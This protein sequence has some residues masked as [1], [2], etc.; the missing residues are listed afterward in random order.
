M[1][2]ITSRENIETIFYEDAD[3]TLFRE[4]LSLF[5]CQI[6]YKE[7][8][9][10]HKS[11]R[12]KGVL[13]YYDLVI[14]IWQRDTEQL[15]Y[16]PTQFIQY[17]KAGSNQSIDKNYVRLNLMAHLW[18]KLVRYVMNNTTVFFQ[19]NLYEKYKL[20]VHG[21]QIDTEQSFARYLLDNANLFAGQEAVYVEGA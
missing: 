4:A 9:G 13:K 17:K 18:K 2:C 21:V 19:D 10:D 16:W 1:G 7:L 20:D 8:W 11:E 12:D 5:N 3:I 14:S 6:A 15:L